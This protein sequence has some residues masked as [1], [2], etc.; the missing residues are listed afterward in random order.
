MWPLGNI[1]LLVCN[2]EAGCSA[3]RLRLGLAQSG[4]QAQSIITILT[5]GLS[6]RCNKAL[7]EAGVDYIDASV[8]RKEWLANKDFKNIGESIKKYLAAFRNIKGST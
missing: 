4:T 3:K 8:F 6:G 7:S 2:K 1:E 5:S